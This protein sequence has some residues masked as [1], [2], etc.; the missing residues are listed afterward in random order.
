MHNARRIGFVH[1]NPPTQFQSTADLI[2]AAAKQEADVAR[3]LANI[4]A[5]D[6]ANEAR[7]AAMTKK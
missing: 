7:V 4:D 6:A 1:P 2:A 3:M 5:L